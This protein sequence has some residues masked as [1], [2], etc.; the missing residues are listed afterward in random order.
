M[1]KPNLLVDFDG[2]IH[3]YV[4]EWRGPARIPDPPVPGAI[5]F[6]CEAQEYF[7]VCIYSSRSCQFLGKWAMKRW[8]RK[9]FIYQVLWQ[10][11]EALMH[12]TIQG[13]NNPESKTEVRKAANRLV[14]S[15]RFPTNKPRAFLTIDDRCVCFTG[16]FL[17]PSELINFKPW[18]K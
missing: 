14:K 10:N 4:S 18:N 3:R 9:H 17:R 2:V 8:I 15:L 12:W 5:K 11:N 7:R 6:L 1:G 13:G 16:H